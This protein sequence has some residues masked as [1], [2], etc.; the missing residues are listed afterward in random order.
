[1]PARLRSHWSLVA[2][3]LA[4]VV[5]LAFL[6]L[7][8]FAWNDYDREAAPALR[9]LGDG[10]VSGFL[11]LAPAYG[12]SLVLRAPFAALTSALGGG[13]LAVYRAVSLP[14]LLAVAIFALVLAGRMLARGASRGTC[15]LV[16]A[17]CAANPVT[18]QALEIGHPEEPLC[19]VLAIGAV[20][21]A[22]RRRVLLSA[23]LLGLAIATK[24]WAVLAIGPVLLALPHR[25][26]LALA[27]AGGVCAAI[28]APL[29]LAGSPESL[30]TC[31]RPARCS[32]R[33]RS[34]GRSA[35]SSTSRSK[36]SLSPAP[37]TRRSGSRRSRTR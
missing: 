9:A 28:M 23:V 8:D 25:R 11:A 37:A 29:L 26:V 17:L 4:G 1:M 13:E 33:G 19:A 34:G 22:T 20:L 18:L 12:G 27:I 24:A 6:G 30:H 35:T 2:A 36:A 32:T 3:A 15:L 10:D 5:V 14:C 16:V 21:A 7:G 31:A